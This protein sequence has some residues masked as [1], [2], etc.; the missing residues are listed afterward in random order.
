M[1]NVGL[2][3]KSSWAKPRIAA[4]KP[5]TPTVDAPAA[6]A[7]LAQPVDPLRDSAVN[8]AGL[9]YNQSLQQAQYAQGQ[10]G[11]NYGL[12]VDAGGGVYDDPSNP[13]SQAAGLQ[14]AYDRSKQSNTTSYASQG[15]LYS[16][17]LQNAQDDAA[18]TNA[19]GRDSLIRNF[20]AANQN[21]Q[22]QKLAA[23]NTLQDRIAQAASDSLARSLA[24]PPDA[25]SLTPAAA[26]AAA[27]PVVKTLTGQKDSQGRPG[28]I[29]V[30]ADGTRVFVRA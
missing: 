20:Q 14:A 4:V 15:Q 11:S 1:A 30:H 18:L 17:A 28:K 8:Q 26:P 10:L 21:I 2:S 6:P 27:N 29:N 7:P 23:G 25:A 24:A 19:R 16:G 22:D 3:W 5:S 9:L 12:G 13:F